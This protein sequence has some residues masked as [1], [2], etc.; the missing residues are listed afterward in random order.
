MVLDRAST[1]S[2]TKPLDIDV[3]VDTKGKRVAVRF[4]AYVSTVDHDE[5]L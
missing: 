2:T 5:L 4:N 3:R 1:Y